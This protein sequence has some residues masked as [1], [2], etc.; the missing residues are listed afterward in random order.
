[1]INDYNPITGNFDVSDCRT[2]PTCQSED[3]CNTM[4]VREIPD[5]TVIDK[6]KSKLELNYTLYNFVEQ[7]A[8]SENWY[9]ERNNEWFGKRH[10][11]D[12]ANEILKEI[13][14]I[15]D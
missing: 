10:I 6:Q 11:G 8:D 12:W 13:K 5:Q 3:E 2:L 14:E 9:G 15:N 7:V 4:P 1:M